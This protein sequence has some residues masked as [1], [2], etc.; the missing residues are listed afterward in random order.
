MFLV[1]DPVSYYRL[2]T[3]IVPIMNNY[4]ISNLPGRGSRGR[5]STRLEKFNINSR[6][7]T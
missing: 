1:R 4:L 7:E 2:G 3:V 5:G 6:V